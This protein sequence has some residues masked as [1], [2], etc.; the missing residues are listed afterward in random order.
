LTF[1]VLIH[2]FCITGDIAMS[3]LGDLE[4]PV[5]LALLR[6]GNDGY[7]VAVQREIA[8]R[9]TRDVSLGAVYS[10]LTRLEEKGFVR[11]RLGEPTPTRGGRRRK[12]YTVEASGREAI[13]DSMDTLR[14]LSR[15]LS[16]ALGLR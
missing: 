11:A 1:S 10:A 15:G 7:G 9:T 14:S 16:P 4:L 5:L 3:S 2:F 13:R 6:L 12:L 8:E